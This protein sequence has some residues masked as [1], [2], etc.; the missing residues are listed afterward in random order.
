MAVAKH[1][2]PNMKQWSIV[3]QR[4]TE[5]QSMAKA[6]KHGAEKHGAA[7]NGA[8]KHGVAKYIPVKHGAAKH[9]AAERGEAITGTAKDG[10]ADTMQQRMREKCV[11]QHSMEQ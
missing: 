7:K 8:V 5:H 2:A 6:A 11:G 4:G 3:E 1:A 9:G 10:T